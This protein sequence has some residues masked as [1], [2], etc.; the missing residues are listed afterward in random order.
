M[1]IDK[2]R[3]I[4]SMPCSGL[5]CNQPV[6][7]VSDT[8]VADGCSIHVDEGAATSRDPKRCFSIADPALRPW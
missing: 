8:A 5:L 7:V 6:S 4:V 3:S 1:A 2:H